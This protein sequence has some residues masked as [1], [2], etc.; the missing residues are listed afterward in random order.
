M[1]RTKKWLF[2]AINWC[3]KLTLT[4]ELNACPANSEYN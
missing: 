1:I 2:L 3:S 4:M